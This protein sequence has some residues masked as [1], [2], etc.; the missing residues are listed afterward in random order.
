M[1]SFPLLTELFGTKKEYVHVIKKL[2][3]FDGLAHNYELEPAA[4]YSNRVCIHGAIRE[5]YPG[6]E[7][8]LAFYFL[9]P[10]KSSPGERNFNKIEEFFHWQSQ[11]DKKFKTYVLFSPLEFNDNEKQRIDEL[12]DKYESPVQLIYYGPSKIESLLNQCSHVKKYL[13]SKHGKALSGGQN[14]VQLQEKYEQHLTRENRHLQFVGLPTGNYQK[15][16]E[17][18]K[19]ELSRVY[20]PLELCERQK[21]KTSLPLEKVLKKSNRAVILGNP[22]TGKSTLAKYLSLILCGAIKPEQKRSF[23]IERKT[24][25]IIPIR[26]L[27][28]VHSGKKRQYSWNT[29]IDH[30]KYAAESNDKFNNIDRDFFLA[31]LEL[32]IAMVIFDGLDE[33]S[34]GN[35]RVEIARAIE[36][37][38]QRFPGIPIWVTSRIVGYTGTAKLDPS[39]FDS[40]S[41]AQVSTEQAR[42]FIRKWYHVQSPFDTVTSDNR[43]QSLQLAIENNVGVKQLKSNPLLL[44]MMALVHQFEGTLPDNRSNLYH[45][46]IELLLKSWQALKYKTTDK[47][48][49]LEARG[50]RYD[51]QLRLLAAAAQ[52][53]QEKKNEEDDDIDTGVIAE[54]QLSDVL[55]DAHFDRRRM[56]IEKAKQD[57]LVFLNYIRDRAGLLVEKGRIQ[58]GDSYFAFVHLSFQEYLWAFRIAE[59]RSKTQHEHINALLKYIAFPMWT[60]PILLTLHLFS[61]SS[62][63]SFVDA[64]TK[65]VF[66]KL[67]KEHIQQGWFL[68][69]RAVRDNINFALADSRK[70]IRSLLNIWLNDIDNTTARTII[71]E[72]AHFSW[73]GSK[74]LKQVIKTTIKT[75]KARQAFAALYLYKELYGLDQRLVKIISKNKHYNE[76]AVYLPVFRHEKYFKNIIH[77]S[78]DYHQWF[79]FYYS[80]T[81]KSIEILNG[82]IDGV[83]TPGQLEGY[84]LCSWR[85]MLEKFNNRIWFL[86]QNNISPQ[87]KRNLHF[88]HNHFADTASVRFPVSIFNLFIPHSIPLASIDSID[89]QLFTLIDESYFSPPKEK[90]IS[91]WVDSVAETTF[92]EIEKKQAWDNHVRREDKEK[93]TQQL[94]I[95]GKRFLRDFT[96]NPNKHVMRDFF[97]QDLMK[98]TSSQFAEHFVRSIDEY[99]TNKE[100]VQSL[101][102]R[103][104]LFFIDSLSSNLLQQFN[105]GLRQYSKLDLARNL[106]HSFVSKRI[107]NL[108]SEFK[109]QVAT[110]YHREFGREI[111]WGTITKETFEAL[112]D[113]YTKMFKEGDEEFIE[114]F[115]NQLYKFHFHLRFTAALVSQGVTAFSFKALAI[116]PLDGLNISDTA[117]IPLIFAFTLGTLLNAHL[118]HLMEELNILYGQKKELKPKIISQAVAA[119]C[120]KS[121][122]FLCLLYYS[123]EKYCDQFYENSQ[124]T[125]NEEIDPLKLAVFLTIAARVAQVTGRLCQGECWKK[126]LKKAEEKKKGNLLVSFSLTL[127]N[128]TTLKDKKTNIKLLEEQFEKIK[129]DFP[130]YAKILGL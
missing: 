38:P 67:R 125:H 126:I 15:Q 80:G 59:D 2:L 6:L 107:K 50:L 101:L 56:T 40:Y 9:W 47:E 104:N 76:L 95:F 57:I 75:G 84:L 37:F 99:I 115:F 1:A 36:S 8:P 87:G 4:H 98:G 89:S 41:L 48:N 110:F 106:I 93:L 24:P 122:F 5:S 11:T 108:E 63:T 16:S 7:C 91:S 127:Y 13:Y 25:F 54:K 78:L 123:W 17:L 28:R 55:L 129:N 120:G 35:G 111:D 23:K 72:I 44:T 45:K 70:I 49:P 62:G 42:E 26:E 96:L 39:H 100:F 81:D 118:I 51:D 82:L 43:T 27:V 32:D 21:D 97:Q 10:Q 119:Y 29:F 83:G 68:L 74:Q 12:K 52:H 102:K 71:E 61:R 90:F 30:L 65:A 94:R 53:V 46:C 124:K 58:G 130:E 3:A 73:E 121:P 112:H 86:E 109:N 103:F 92:L 69:A 116:E 77:D 113:F 64:F 22:G 14:F 114:E 79:S 33:V 18:E 105:Q 88:L 20:I 60:E 128:L 85:R 31:L 19:P 66:E 34:N 117:A